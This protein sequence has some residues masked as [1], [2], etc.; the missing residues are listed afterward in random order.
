MSVLAKGK[1]DIALHPV[2]LV[3]VEVG[4]QNRHHQNQNARSDLKDHTKKARAPGPPTRILPE[5]P[6][7]KPK[8]KLVS[9]QETVIVI[10]CGVTCQ[11][12]L[13]FWQ[14]V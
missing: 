14:L 4:E 5:M 6:V 2:H 1:G 11:S 12:V 13:L 8:G 10:M 9:F 3:A 7:K